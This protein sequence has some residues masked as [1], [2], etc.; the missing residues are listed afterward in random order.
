MSNPVTFTAVFEEL[1][2]EDGGGF[3]AYVEELPGAISQGDTL[4]EAR[5]NLADAIRT[6]LDAHRQ[7]AA[8]ASP[9]HAVI[10]EPISI[11]AA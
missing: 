11:S 7:L 2:P 9:G 5:E 3:H 6:L 1:S 8:E 10:R 4:E